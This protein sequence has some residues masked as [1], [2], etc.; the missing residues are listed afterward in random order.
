MPFLL[1]LILAF[2]SPAVV[3]SC[4]FSALLVAAALVAAVVSLICASPSTALARAGRLLQRQLYRPAAIQAMRSH[5][6]RSLVPLGNGG[7]AR[8]QPRSVEPTSELQSR[9]DISCQP[10]YQ[11]K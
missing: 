2:L 10:L 8:R 4:L 11:I 7:M 6:T 9:A 1:F 5:R 3:G